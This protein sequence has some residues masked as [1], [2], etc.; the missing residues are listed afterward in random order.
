MGLVVS[1][2]TTLTLTSVPPDR[3]IVLRGPH[4]DASFVVDGTV[5][6]GVL[7]M[8]SVF[9]VMLLKVVC[10]FSRDTGNVSMRGLAVFFAFF[11]VL[12]F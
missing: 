11:I 3:A 2:F 12:R 1:A 4:H 6:S 10:C 9:L 5:E 7:K 8:N